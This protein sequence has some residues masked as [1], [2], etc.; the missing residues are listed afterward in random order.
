MATGAAIGVVV[1]IFVSVATD[2]P[3]AP[4]AGLAIGVLIGWVT[5]P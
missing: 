5:T 1:G 2:I 3:L 4:E